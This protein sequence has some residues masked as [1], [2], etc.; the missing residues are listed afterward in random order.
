MFARNSLPT[1]C[2]EI[3]AATLPF[4]TIGLLGDRITLYISLSIGVLSL[5]FLGLSILF[6]S[7][8]P[9]YRFNKIQPQDFS[10]PYAIAL[11][12]T[13]LRNNGI[14]ASIG[15]WFSIGLSFLIIISNVIIVQ[16]DSKR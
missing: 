11:S 12:A 14:N 9:I 15:F 16:K 3:L 2:S 4:V 13:I 10:L 1:I 7:K 8:I 6:K 5:L